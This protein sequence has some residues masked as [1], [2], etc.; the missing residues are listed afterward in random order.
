MKRLFI[1]YLL[2]VHRWFPKELAETLAENEDVRETVVRL[3]GARL[4]MTL[5]EAP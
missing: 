4:L 1:A 2:L 5:E 3:G